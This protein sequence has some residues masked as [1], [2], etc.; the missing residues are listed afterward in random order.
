MEL[1][2]PYKMITLQYKYVKKSGKQKD[3][4]QNINIYK[5]KS[6]LYIFLPSC[7]KQEF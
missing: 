1:P 7:Y 5:G 4:S 2:L 6:S 3:K